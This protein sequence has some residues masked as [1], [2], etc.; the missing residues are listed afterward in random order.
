MNLKL[1][2]L[3]ALFSLVLTSTITAQSGTLD[4]TYAGTGIQ[5]LQPGDLHD[6]GH[7][8]IALADSTS[9]VC[10][11]A[12]V[13]G[14]NSAFV[15]HLLENGDR[16]S[17]WGQNNGYTFISVGLEAYAYDMARDAQGNIYICGT[18]YVTFDHSDVLL[19]RL[20][21]NGTP[22]DT[23]GTNGVQTYT[24]GTGDA[25]A[26]SIVIQDDGK[27]ILAGR[28]GFGDLADALVMRIK[29]NGAA[30]GAFGDA[31]ILMTAAYSGNEDGF[32]GVDLLA[33]G[34]VVTAG[35]AVVNFL[36]RAVVAMID[37]N[38]V[39]VDSF[40]GDG[41]LELGLPGTEH[42]CWSIIG[43]EQSMIVCGHVQVDPSNRDL[44]VARVK[45]NGVTD[46]SYGTNGIT[47]TD[48]DQNDVAYDIAK[49][50]DG[51]V[52]VCGT[53]GSFGFFVPRDV[54]VVR[55]TASG[56]IDD[57][58][59]TGGTTVTNIQPDFDDANGVDIQPDGKILACGFT[60]GVDNDLVVVRY[61]GDDSSTGMGNSASI[62]T[63]L[64]AYPN[65]VGNTLFIDHTLQPQ[66]QLMI[67]DGTGRVVTR[68]AFGTRG[69]DVSMFPAGLYRIVLHNSSGV[70]H[71]QFVKN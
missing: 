20:L 37:T 30:D 62:T 9:L 51:K 38:G 25:E 52:V 4:P 24:V 2:H 34:A 58:F 41:V 31:G 65:P 21:P 28:A 43:E 27:I 36:G 39:F 47:I 32:Y 18:A 44:F 5:L 3:V 23:F 56:Q 11:V 50:M 26:Q 22:D 35:Y 66:D 71:T 69:I 13:N 19:A 55:Y 67:L 45:T 70:H 61:L 59:G 7:E 64:Q 33:D 29:D 49:Q 6:V 1:T 63:S 12:H 42:Q 40:D 14:T 46:I 48:V 68:P 15:L 60:A 53:T 57:T 17:D 54:V 8:V 16:D 10:G